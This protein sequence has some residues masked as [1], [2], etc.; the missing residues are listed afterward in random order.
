VKPG[1]ELDALVAEKVMGLKFSPNKSKNWN[2]AIDPEALHDFEIPHYSTEI[3]A[4]WEVRAEVKKWLFSR[5]LKFK[6]ALQ[7][8]I[9]DRVGFG[10]GVVIHKEEMILYA[11]PVDICL[12]AL[13]AVGYEA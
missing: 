2:L 8:A 13:K 10:Q 1:R 3:A 12:A 4:A 11:E 9:T 5:K 6:D 7:R